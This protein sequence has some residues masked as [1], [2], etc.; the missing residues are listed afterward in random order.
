[1]PEAASKIP[2]MAMAILVFQAEGEKYERCLI[3]GDTVG[4]AKEHTTLCWCG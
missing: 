4:E 2:N 3:D 1:V